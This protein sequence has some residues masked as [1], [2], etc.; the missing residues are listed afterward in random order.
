[1]RLLVTGGAGYIGSIVARLLLSQRHEVAVLD[2]LLRGQ[3]DAVPAD[4]S[5][6]VADQLD[7]EA[8]EA[9]LDRQ[10][11]AVLHF[12]AL[13]LVGSLERRPASREAGRRDYSPSAA[14]SS[15]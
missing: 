10:F 5:S 13:A 2:N 15:R 12:A 8:L 1:M 4:A 6:A 9:V 7:R 3:R 14:T 11:D